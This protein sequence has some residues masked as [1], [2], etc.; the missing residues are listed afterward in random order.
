MTTQ[1]SQLHDTAVEASYTAV[2]RETSSLH[3]VTTEQVSDEKL[4]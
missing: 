3:T 4:C 2:H 1:V